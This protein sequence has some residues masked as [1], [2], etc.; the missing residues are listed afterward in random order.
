MVA[1]ELVHYLDPEEPIIAMHGSLTFLKNPSLQD[2]AQYLKNLI[3]QDTGLNISR[4]T[5]YCRLQDS[6]R[7]CLPHQKFVK[8]VSLYIWIYRKLSP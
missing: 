8:C 5:F 1:V 2:T 6:T 7:Q 4:R 3:F